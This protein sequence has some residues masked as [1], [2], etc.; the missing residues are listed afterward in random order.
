MVKSLVPLHHDA[1]KY[2]VVHCSATRCNQ[3]FPVERLINTGVEKFGQ[4]SY[5]YYV[6]RNGSIVPILPESVRGIH[7][8]GYNHCSIAVCYEGGLDEHGDAADTRTELQKHALYELLKQLHRDYPQARII[9]HRELPRVAKKCPC[10]TAS[11]EYADLQ[12]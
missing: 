7:A 9:G 8:V 10:Y 3:D 1:V 11:A 6:R 2:L 12:P 5:H 4:A